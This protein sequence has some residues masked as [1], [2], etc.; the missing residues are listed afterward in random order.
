MV[1]PRPFISEKSIRAALDSLLYTPRP[2]AQRNPLQYLLL[3]DELLLNPVVP[4]GENSRAYALQSVL[5][6][7]IT[8]NLSR[9]RTVHDLQDASP[10]DAPDIAYSQLVVD[11]QTGNPELMAWSLLYY[12]Y[13]R[14]DLDLTLDGIS[15]Q[16]FLDQRTLRRYQQHGV[17]RLTETLTALETEARTQQ[18][19][20]RLY[21]ALPSGT[22]ARLFGFERYFAQ[23]AEA[24]KLNLFPIVLVTGMS[25]AGKSAFVQEA[26][27]RRIDETEI[28][29]VI[30]IDEPTTEASI[31]QQLQ[32]AFSGS[33]NALDYRESLRLF[34][35]IIVLD[36]VSAFVEM[37]DHLDNI[38]ERLSAA[39]I[40]LTSSVFLPLA[41]IHAH[42]RLQ[43][44]G[45]EGF[46]RLI[47]YLSIDTPD[48][49]DSLSKHEVESLWQISEGHPLTT[50]L[51]YRS[52]NFGL[53]QVSR[54]DQF[55]RKAL[56]Q[57][58]SERGR[59]AL[60]GTALIG[61]TKIK[62]STLEQCW[63]QFFLA[64]EIHLL[65]KRHIVQEIS[66][67]EIL[68]I[69]PTGICEAL[70]RW[71][72]SQQF[73]NGLLNK[74]EELIFNQPSAAL[75]LAQPILEHQSGMLERQQFTEW[76]RLLS[77]AAL[78][79][80][81][82]AKWLRLIQRALDSAG[83]KDVELLLSLGICLRWVGEWQ[84][85][86]QAFK[87][88]ILLAGQQGDFIAQSKALVEHAILSRSQGEYIQALGL[89][90]QASEVTRRCPDT[91]ELQQQI[92]LE[93]VQIAVDRGQCE[94][95]LKFLEGLSIVSPHSMLL[96]S[97]IA[98]LCGK[99]DKALS[100]ALQFQSTLSSQAIS[101]ATEGRIYTVIGRSYAEK[102]D[103]L[104]AE[105]YLTLAVT[106][107]E[108]AGNPFAL[109]RAQLNLASVCIRLNEHE[110]AQQLI[111]RCE[112][113]Q[114]KLGDQVAL[115]AVRH[116]LSILKA[117]ITR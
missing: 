92:H 116:N 30:W 25:G 50:I 107:M 80:G 109:A 15:R 28:D 31:L 84:Q 26:V 2:E 98:L 13:V 63:G 79:A 78:K 94:E 74:L 10:R 67:G 106:C 37:P 77:P 23:M 88:A 113:I 86:R 3:V 55:F 103:L 19:R 64:D 54:L 6:D 104:P 89:L 33:L 70:L 62:I 4:S 39:E 90:R 44:L 20:R 81:H 68:S 73:L 65:Q 56:W 76:I 102:G 49:M 12:R 101:K 14:S 75:T 51:A 1:T 8:T 83:D 7:A 53:S 11:F 36:E 5:L 18:H 111:E 85:A 100:I 93:Q 99:P 60:I 32:A 117:L 82:Y 105:H 114:R 97:E 46:R 41:R 115:A 43:N 66:P 95:G 110:E 27:R 21:T 57:S 24:A 72:D 17:R 112:V 45:R 91:V 35:T 87:E 9:L 61:K 58:L 52:L 48:E 16:V 40:Y 29:Y 22:K 38:L 59:Y 108:L 69:I 96:R 42:I 47:E 34:H 71:K